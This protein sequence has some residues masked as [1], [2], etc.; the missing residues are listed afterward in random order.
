MYCC[1]TVLRGPICMI[2]SQCELMIAELIADSLIALLSLS[3]IMYNIIL[4]ILII[5]YIGFNEIIQDRRQ[6][7]GG[8]VLGTLALAL[9]EM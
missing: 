4:I 5:K 3:V 8:K 2:A 6:I 1:R 9:L 7:N